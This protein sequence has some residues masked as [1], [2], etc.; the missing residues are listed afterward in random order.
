MSRAERL[1]GSLRVSACAGEWDRAAASALPPTRE[2]QSAAQLDTD[3]RAVCARLMGRCVPS[4]RVSRGGSWLS[5][6][7]KS[8]RGLPQ[9]P[10]ATPRLLSGFVV[11][12]ARAGTTPLPLS[13][14]AAGL[15]RT[16]A[17]RLTQDEGGFTDGKETMLFWH[18]P[19]CAKSIVLGRRC[20]FGRRNLG[21][22][23]RVARAGGRPH[24]DWVDRPRRDGPLL[25]E[26]ARY[27][28]SA[29]SPVGCGNSPTAARGSDFLSR[30][31][32]HPL[33]G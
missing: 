22:G 11:R 24:R 2:K 32:N 26:R 14:S 9:T 5:Q 16:A 10:N 7:P 6:Q 19:S 29:T 27:G 31:P 23:Q 18:A 3:L 33:R 25:A 15:P 4:W 28:T 17:Q 13:F 12:R 20:Q 21:W 30:G 1:R 8:D